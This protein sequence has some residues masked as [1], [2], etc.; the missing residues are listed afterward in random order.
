MREARRDAASPP[1]EVPSSAL[2][3]ARRAMLGVRS[4]SVLAALT[5]GLVTL[6][7]LVRAHGAGLA[8]PD[9]PRCFGVWLPEMDLRVG[10]E[11]THRLVAGS[12]SLLFALAAALVLRD[13]RLRAAA[14]RPIALAFALLALQIVLGGL[15]VLLGLAP[16]TVTAHL[17]TGTSFAATLCWIALALRDAAAPRPRPALPTGAR[18]AVW[19]AAALVL[20]Q[21]TLGGLVSSNYAGLDC[22][23]WPTCRD[24][25]WFPSL[26]GGVGLHLV[27]RT[28]AY[29]MV[30]AI[31]VALWLNRRHPGVA[32]PLRLATALV[33]L[34]V[35]LG[36]ANVRLGLRI[37]VTGLHTLFA[38]LLALCFAAALREVRL[39][40]VGG[41]GTRQRVVIVGA[42][43]GGLGVARALADT[44]V[45]VLVVD[46]E[47]YHAFLPLLYQVA[48]SGLSAQDVTH[49]VRSI[50]RRLPNARFRMAEVAH[51]DLG[52]RTI[53]TAGGAR[54]PYDVL[55]IAAGSTTE[56][57][58]NESVERFTFA[59]HHVDEA[60]ALRNHVLE[61]LERAS[62]TEDANER[63]A[64]LG[65]VLV[66]GGPTGVEL[67]GMLGELRKHVVP[68]DFPGL[69]AAMRVVLLEGRDRLLAA[70]PESLCRRA[71]E[72]VRELG[73][74]V[75][76]GAIVESVDPGGVQLAS[77]DRI[78]A[79]TVVW[80]A[81]VRGAKIG[82]SLGV[83]LGRAARV[84]VATTLQVDG[85]PEVY[86]IGD[87]ALVRGMESLPQVAQVAI[88]QGRRVAANVQRALC[89]AEP[90]PFRYWDPGMMATIG[91]D[92]AV[93]MLFGVKLAGRIAW[94]F[95]L[96]A[97]IVFLAGFR[98]RASVF[99]NW[100]YH[101]L[102]Y[103]LG[104][105]AIVG[106][107]RKPPQG[108]AQ[109]GEAERSSSKPE[110]DQRS[111]DA[112]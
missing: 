92:R 28:N 35:L 30:L 65:F 74:E 42:G 16:W 11:W 1:E 20:A 105:R 19:V 10:F 15:T 24:G 97:H 67:S 78:P 34:Q 68:R 25:V 106:R 39:R 31:G 29:L 32:R 53:E 55:V 109:R 110:P 104:L 71:L 75:R 56:F 14:R 27:H 99:V 43:F 9:W 66:G 45:D 62:E 70:F 63:E 87:L 47:N 93:A 5:L 76:F 22:P 61:C 37:E 8:C 54:I 58:G 85:H 46:R 59:L 108:D 83:P 89:G 77:G 44:P 52:E 50:L 72:Q 88:Q 6:G 3:D 2:R 4:F 111:S 86:A 57:F 94:F 33:L 84:P 40:P 38:A 73:V 64:L 7:A 82:A 23:E 18:R 60:I 81:G 90:L 112:A 69:A 21:I 91:R 98:N 48:T 95:W 96:V 49:P 101:Y 100:I 41:D 102:T 13:A 12:I 17:V 103:D 26:E 79:R 51:L 80:A 36:I 107:T